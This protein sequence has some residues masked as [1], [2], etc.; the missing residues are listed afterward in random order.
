[1]AGDPYFTLWEFIKSQIL[2]IITAITTAITAIKYLTKKHDEKYDNEIKRLD[3]KIDSLKEL[4]I[5]N[6]TYLKDWFKSH[7]S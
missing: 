7:G 2:F 5:T 6:V 1:M 4:F 3:T